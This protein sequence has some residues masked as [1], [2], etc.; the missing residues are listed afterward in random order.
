VYREI[1]NIIVVLKE[2]GCDERWLNNIKVDLPE[3][4][5]EFVDWIYL[6]VGRN[7][8]RAFLVK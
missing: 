6:P 5:W 3:M 1:C 8:C 2:I 4:E 7:Q